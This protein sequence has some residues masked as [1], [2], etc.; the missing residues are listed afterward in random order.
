MDNNLL[1]KLNSFTRREFGEDEVYIFSVIL[2][3][4]EIDRDNER[5][6]LSALEKLCELYVGKTGIFDHNAKAENQSAR[7]FDTELVSDPERKTKCGENYTCLKANAY[8]VKTAS[9]ADL[10]KEIDGGIKKEVSVSCSAGVRKCSVC[11]TDTK[12]KPCRHVGGKTYSGVP[13][14]F[15]LEDINDVYEWSFV[16]VPAQTHAGVTK[17]FDGQKESENEIASSLYEDVKK[18]VI[19][20]SFLSGIKL[21]KGYGELL[22]RMSAEELLRLRSELMKSVPAQ[23]TVQT[24]MKK[25]AQNES[26]RI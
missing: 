6:S 15:I 7:I 11:K 8:M 5:F 19:R 23:F 10:I 12:V 22:D 2:C 1:E 26:Y 24:K 25:N 18:D 3:D 17:H 13:C 21:E 14:H 4:N 20:L 16:A 9:N